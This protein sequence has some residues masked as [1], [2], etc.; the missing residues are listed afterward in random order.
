[1]SSSNVSSSAAL[2]RKLE[3]EVAAYEV[4]KYTDWSMAAYPL[5]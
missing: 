3:F 2:I 5:A 4:R 1:M